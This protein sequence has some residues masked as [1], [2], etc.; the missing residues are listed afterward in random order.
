MHTQGFRKKCIQKAFTSIYKPQPYKRDVKLL[1]NH[2]ECMNFRLSINRVP[3]ATSVHESGG[4]VSYTTNV[5]PLG[6]I[7]YNIVALDILR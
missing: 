4:N 5:P 6:Y 3:R 2:K 7:H 1:K